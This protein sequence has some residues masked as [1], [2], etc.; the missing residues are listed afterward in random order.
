VQLASGVALRL[1]RTTCP[2][3]SDD[4]GAPGDAM[5]CVYDVTEQLRDHAARDA[6]ASLHEAVL[7]LD[8]A[9]RVELINEAAAAALGVD[10]NRVVG[11][12][13]DAAIPGWEQIRWRVPITTAPDPSRAGTETLP[14]VTGERVAWLRVSAVRLASGDV[15]YAFADVTDERTLEYARGDFVAV[16]S[17][18]LR[19]P[20]ASVYGAAL[21]LQRQDLPADS[22]VRQQLVSIIAS[23]AHRLGAIISDI[24]IASRID[25][26]AVDFVREE[27]DGRGVVEDV[28]GSV[29]PRL[30]PRHNLELCGEAALGNVTNGELHMTGDDG[31]VRQVLLNLVE[32][33]IRYSPDGGVI[34]L[35]LAQS[36]DGSALHFWVSDNGLG[37]P[38]EDLPHVF[39]KFYRVD[40]NSSRATSGTGLGL[41]ISREL[42]T[43][44]G[45]VIRVESSL[46]A[47]ST[48]HVVL[49]KL[50]HP[51]RPGSDAPRA[52][53]V[54][55]E[56]VSASVSH[57]GRAHS[58]KQVRQA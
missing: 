56:D 51:V 31:R 26:G 52:A 32:N 34:Q 49:P 8:P 19:T 30:E 10:V 9:G 24:L 22:D 40:P 1:E 6:L 39:K 35:G 11:E 2:P 36:G 44:M 47:G 46:G 14:L 18:E 3:G 21:T 55:A 54:G 12:V 45:G 28:V 33:A 17:H 29:A 53:R 50:A 57:A 15:A 38:A 41:Y 48:F 42:V 20:L 23:E 4:D 27:F 13:A 58:G 5:W 16:V 7:V 43:R 37:I 25:S